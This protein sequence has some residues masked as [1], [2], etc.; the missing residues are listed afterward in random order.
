MHLKH[1]PTT[2]DELIGLTSIK[3]SI[4]ESTFQFDVPVMFMGERG[5]GKTTL[6]GILARQF[7]ANEQTTRT[8]N[9]GYYTKIDDMRK[10]IDM[11]QK[12]SLYGTKK[13]LILDEIHSLSKASYKAWLTPLENLPANVMVIACTTE[14]QMIPEMLLERFVSFKFSPLTQKESRL[15]IEQVLEKEGLDIPKW[16]K[17]KVIE[18]SQGIPRRILTAL[19]KVIK[20]KDESEV[21]DLLQILSVDQEAEALDVLKCLLS[22]TGWGGVKKALSTAVKDA[23]PEKIRLS[24]MNLIGGRLMSNFATN[25]AEL[26]RLSKFYRALQ[27]AE[28]YP[29]KANLIIAVYKAYYDFANIRG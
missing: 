27:L 17:I 18:Q 28:G 16:V 6:A 2:Y 8:I 1:R 14:P 23:T 25:D 29:E 11:L 19:P 10:E 3:K 5:C 4:S 13:V 9:C 12:T 22:K 20:I 24:L 26:F 7:G 21:D 15:L